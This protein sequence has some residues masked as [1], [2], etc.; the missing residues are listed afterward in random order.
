MNDAIDIA[1]VAAL[2]AIGQPLRRKED[3]RLLTGNGRF[4]DDF[5]MAEQAYAVMVRSPY[6]HARII[7]VDGVR[8]KQMPG[9]LAVFSGADCLADGLGPIPHNPVPPTR[10]D[11]KLTGPGGGAIFIG[12]QPLLPVDKARH[13]GEAVAR[14]LAETLPQARSERRMRSTSPGIALRRTWLVFHCRRG[15]SHHITM[16]M[17]TKQASFAPSSRCGGPVF[18]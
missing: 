3:H 16:S 2:G 12:L 15:L 13:V 9:V 14:V 7:A 8:A 4:T 17:I 1:A 5:N 10:Y 18:S 11:L 6:P